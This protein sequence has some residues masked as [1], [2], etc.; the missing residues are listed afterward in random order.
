MTVS[1]VT[2]AASPLF[3]WL[4]VV[5]CQLGLDGAACA[6]VACQVAT[7]IGLLGYTAYRAWAHQGAC[8]SR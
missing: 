1:A 6:F 7:L 2:L 8:G 4:L 3:F 5:R